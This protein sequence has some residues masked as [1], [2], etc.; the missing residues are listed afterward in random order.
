M[1]RRRSFSPSQAASRQGTSASAFCR[2][3]IVLGAAFPHCN[4]GPSD[5][6][7]P[8]DRRSSRRSSCERRGDRTHRA[9]SCGSAR[10]CHWFAGSWSWC[11]NGRY[12]RA[13]DR[14]RIR[15]ARGCRNIPC[16]DPSARGRPHLPRIIERHDAIV[17]EIS[18]GDGRLAIIELGEGDLG[19]GVDEG[20]LVDAADPLHVADVERIL[21]AA[22]ARTFALELAM[23]LLFALG[24]LQRGEL[25]FGQH[26]TLPQ[27]T[28]ASSA[29]S[30]FFIVSRSWRCQTPRTPA[31]EIEWPSLRSS[32]AMRIWP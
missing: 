16:R 30:R 22:I 29:L 4:F 10:R 21:G 32:L 28:L 1:I 9:P 12:P 23:R 11:A 15:G 8:G 20:L 24:L 27:A 31:G 13:L 2:S 25:A 3:T 14:A 7:R 19:I 18:R 6:D 17:E 26:Q 5:Q